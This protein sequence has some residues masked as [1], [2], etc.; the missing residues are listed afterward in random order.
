MSAERYRGSYHITRRTAL[1][2]IS[3]SGSCHL[4]KISRALKE[5]ITLKKTIERLSRG[6][7][8]FTDGEELLNN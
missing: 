2:G 8:S 6:L 4:S 1:Y 7:D 5:D 3:E